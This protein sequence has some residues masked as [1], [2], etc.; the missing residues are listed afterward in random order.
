MTE[1]Q[2]T[3]AIVELCRYL[4]VLVHHDRPARTER[5]WR[6]AVQGHEGFPDLVI[7]GSGGVLW[8]ELKS[9]RGQLTT[10]QAM[11]LAKLRSAGADFAT[12]RTSDWPTRIRAEI[13]AVA[14]P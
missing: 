1:Q 2:L 13:E 4:G 14:R 6:T 10:H 9:E 7:V 8:R 5:G 11:W 3:D 12:W